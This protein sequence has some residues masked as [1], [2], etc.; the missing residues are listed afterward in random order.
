MTEDPIGRR[1]DFAAGLA[2]EAGRLAL[3]YFDAR[4][5]LAVK[6]KGP[7]DMATEADLNVESLIRERLSATFPEDGFVGEETGGEAAD[8]DAAVW[9]VDPIDGTACFVVGIPTWC[10]SIGFARAGRIELGVIYDPNSDELFVGRRGHGATLNGA[11]M[12]IS[13]ADDFSQGMTG[14]GFS[15]RVDPPSFVGVADRLLR[16]GGMLHRCGSGALSLAYVAAG[17][18]N[19][20]Y[21]PHMNAWDSVAGVALV[22]AAGG[23]TNDVLANGGLAKGSAVLAAAPGLKDALQRLVSCDG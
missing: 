19:G 13:A 6:D 5:S 2:R 21:E 23:W 20:Y 1:M 8:A 22:Q 17:R 9:V 3:T 11:E 12:R 18:L 14:L 4:E 16:A 10:V 15:H 7:Q